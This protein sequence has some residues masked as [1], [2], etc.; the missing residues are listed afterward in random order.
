M[1]YDI[2]KK[3]DNR[4]RMMEIT[5]RFGEKMILPIAHKHL[6]QS[7]IYHCLARDASYARFMH[8]KGFYGGGKCF[9]LFCFSDIRGRY[10]LSK[11]G[12][13]IHFEKHSKLIL[14]STERYLIELLS[15]AWREGS[16]L[17]IGDNTVTIESVA[18]S[19]PYIQSPI[20]RVR[21]LSPII[22][23]AVKDGYS[24]FF[25]PTEPEFYRSCE[26]TARRKWMAYG[27]SS[28]EF[29]LHISG[30]TFRRV[31][32]LFKGTYLIAYNGC[33]VIESAPSIITFLLNVG[34]G[35]KTSSGFGCIQ[36]MT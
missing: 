6:V 12:D 8:D 18:I 21:T 16:F 14:R 3:T 13:E 34:L 35:S 19:D 22:C 36:I 10:H 33:F 17:R 1:K 31:T 4:G 11:N 30:Q 24:R 25:D 32:T 7:M 15:E 23:M 28:D 5:I 27:R 2:L 26:L 29:Y 20:V 9:K